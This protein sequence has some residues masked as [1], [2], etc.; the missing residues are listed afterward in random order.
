MPWQPSEL[1]DPDL[2]AL[3]LAAWLD[4]VA[5]AE[6][7]GGTLDPLKV[8]ANVRRQRPEASPAALAAALTQARLRVRARDRL[9]SQADQFLFTATGLEQATRPQVAHRRAR[10]L[11]A[12][13][14]EHIVDAGAGLGFDAIEFA[15]AGMRVDAVEIDPATADLLA[16]NVRACGVDHL[17]RVVVADVRDLKLGPADAC[18]ADPARRSGD[19][20]LNDPDSWSPPWSWLCALGQLTPRLVAKVAPG[21][22]HD[23]APAGC[24]TVWTSVNGQLVEAAVWWPGLARA[25]RRAAVVIRSDSAVEVLSR[26]DSVAPAAGPAGQWLLEPDDAILRAGLV[27]EVVNRVSGRLLDHRTAY[28]TT[29]ADPGPALDI[30]RAWPILTSLPF[31][32]ASLR[33]ELAARDIGRVVVKKRAFAADPDDVLRQL[34]L[35]GDGGS[36]VVFLTRVGSAPI[37]LVCGNEVRPTSE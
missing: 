36:G 21:I 7:G 13:G 34:K 11:Q 10:R 25:N 29:D 27:D 9:G 28:V 2:L 17:V 3:A 16:A 23:L 1:P 20:R 26:T 8:S 33:R 35:P 4:A 12:A 19:R 32:I 31:S 15:R 14:I 37:A 22:D 6:R 18:F 5:A 24:E 30:A